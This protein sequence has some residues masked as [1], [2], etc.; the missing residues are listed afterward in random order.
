MDYTVVGIITTPFWIGYPS[1]N[2]CNINK[3]YTKYWHSG[4]GSLFPD[5]SGDLMLPIPG[6]FQGGES[7]PKIY[8]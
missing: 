4:L 3:E 6:C 1:N 8:T 5:Q 2:C 7:Y